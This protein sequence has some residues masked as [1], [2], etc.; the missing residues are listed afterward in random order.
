MT[1]QEKSYLYRLR[2]LCDKIEDK[3]DYE[4]FYAVCKRF[5]DFKR[6]LADTKNITK[7]ELLEILVEKG[8]MSY[9]RDEATGLFDKLPDDRSLRKSMRE[10]LKKGFPIIT[11][12]HEDGCFIVE[13]EDEVAKPQK[14]NHSRAVAILAVDKGYNL[15][16]EFVR[17]GA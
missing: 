7:P 8:L 17:G 6:G 10:L 12:S 14:E 16:R 3:F 2:E 1:E 9:R 11:T 15:V 5:M 4:V 13:N